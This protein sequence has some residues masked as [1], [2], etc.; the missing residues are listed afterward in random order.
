MDPTYKLK[1]IKNKTEIKNIKRSHLIDGIAL[2]KFILWLKKNFKNKKITEISA[3]NKLKILEKKTYLIN[4]LVLILFPE[5][6]LI[7]Q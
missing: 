3:Q 1:A 5:A 6:V 2:T 7:V 4:I